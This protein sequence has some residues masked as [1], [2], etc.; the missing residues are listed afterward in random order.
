MP[1]P[2]TF[3]NLIQSV[4]TLK[5]FHNELRNK[6]WSSCEDH[7]V[8]Q[9]ILCNYLVTTKAYSENAKF[10]LG[11]LRCTAQLLSDTLNLKHQQ[12]AEG[13]SRNTL[14]LTDASKRDSATIRAITGVTL[15]YLPTTFVAVSHESERHSHLKILTF[16]DSVRH[17]AFRFGSHGESDGGLTPALD[18][19]CARYSL[20]CGHTWVLEVGR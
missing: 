3:D 9:E 13:I 17:A 10:L 1:L 15:L 12:A 20:H 7:K 19:L 16:Q 18:L 2:Y 5:A 14:M 6:E 8:A 11:K 4:Q